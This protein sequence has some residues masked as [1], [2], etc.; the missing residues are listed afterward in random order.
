MVV[1]KL[2]FMFV[3]L[4]INNV[5]GVGLIEKPFYGMEVWNGGVKI[6]QNPKL[7]T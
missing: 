6:T 1:S 4:I 5:N 7:L 3:G 2:G